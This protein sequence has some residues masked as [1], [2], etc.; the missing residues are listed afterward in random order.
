[1]GQLKKTL[2]DSTTGLETSNANDISSQNQ[3]AFFPKKLK[4]SMLEK[5]DPKAYQLLS[6]KDSQIY[7]L[8][9]SKVDYYRVYGNVQQFIDLYQLFVPANTNLYEGMTIPAELSKDGQVHQV[10]TKEEFE[11]FY[12]AQKDNELNK[13]RRV[14]V[15]Q[16]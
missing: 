1:M 15:E 7:F 9:D 4:G 16:N 12:D 6:K 8:T 5:I 11:T 2:E 10:N 14:L 13:Q 3:L